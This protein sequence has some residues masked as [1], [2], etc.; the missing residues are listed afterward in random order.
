MK[1]NMSMIKMQRLTIV[2]VLILFSVAALTY[3]VAPARAQLV[4]DDNF[5]GNAGTV[6]LGTI[7]PGG[8]AGSSRAL[9]LSCS[10]Q[11]HAE[12]GD[13][14]F[15]ISITG[16]YASEVS[17]V[18]SLTVPN[19][20]PTDGNGCGNPKPDDVAGSVTIT[21]TVPSGAAGGA[22]SIAIS[23]RSQDSDANGNVAITVT[24]T[25]PSAPSDT[26][27]PVLTK[28][29][30][31]PKFVSG[32]TTYVKSTTP[33]SVTAVDE[34]GGSGL[35]GCTISGNTQNNGAYS[36][37]TDFYLTS[38]DGSKTFT[39]ECTDN[40][41]NSAHI[42]ETDVVDDT[43]PSLAKTVGSPNY[44]DGV[45]TYVKSTTDISVAV[46]ESGSGLASCSLS[47]DTQNN[48]AYT[49]GAAFHLTTPDG[50][51]T[52]SLTCE[53]HLGNQGGLSETDIV[54]D[55]PPVITIT[56]PV[57]IYILNQPSVTVSY[58]CDDGSGSGVATCTGPL[59]NDAPVDTNAAALGSHTFT[60]TSTDNLGNGPRYLSSL[61]SVEYSLTCGRS[62][63]QPLQQVNDP[64]GLTKRYKLGSTLPIKFQLCDYNNKP[65]A[66]A[67]A[68]L[69]ITQISTSVDSGD[70]LVNLDSGSSNDNT[71]VFRYDSTAQQ[72]IY[73]LSTKSTAF[74]W[75]TGTYKITITLDDNTA[76]TTYFE[77]GK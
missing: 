52:F 17:A 73:N 39:V 42:T 14:L 1:M 9:S 53:D 27:P 46:T 61:Y 49:S 57:G 63:L 76:I 12:H 74:P 28:S 5:G 62:V 48:G 54:D 16:T 67:I 68:K 24:Y 71:N 40:A 75:A 66:T 38:G 7:S 45:N 2:L 29:I 65:V 8:S 60:V 36:Q 31:D 56:S 13:M 55:T 34:A 44:N 77:L 26:T 43:P 30:G 10:G 15:T 72:Y 47:G 22:R 64:S 37:G 11:S 6:N 21:A 41:G 18:A 35:A 3:A 25:V 32:S 70:V 59:A 4:D 51:K 50:S 69:S 58:S 20:W 23:I 33:I 19:T